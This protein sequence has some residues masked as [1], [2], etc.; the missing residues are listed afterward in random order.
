[1]VVTLTNEVTVC[2]GERV[3]WAV[4]HTRGQR[5]TVSVSQSQSKQ[6]KCSGTHVAVLTRPKRTSEN[7]DARS[8]VYKARLN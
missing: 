4:K 3:C 8:E 7:G 6:Q 1:M 5:A 2:N